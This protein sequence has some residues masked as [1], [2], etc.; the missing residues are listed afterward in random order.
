MM[1]NVNRT[2]SV[3][4]GV[5]GVIWAFLPGVRF[6]PG[7]LGISDPTKPIPKWFAR[8][9]FLAIGLWFIY[10][11]LTGEVPLLAEKVVA[12]SIGLTIIIAGV[13]TKK[14]HTDAARMGNAP[15]V[16]KRFGGLLFLVVGLFFILVG[17]ALKR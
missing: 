10:G 1:T 13:F 15:S 12:V 7:G 14:P 2:I 3:A 5:A 17:L 4:V 11:G 9:C 6:Y 8:F 16:P